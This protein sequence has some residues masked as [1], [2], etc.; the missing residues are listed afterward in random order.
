MSKK[1]HG[2]TT[3][4]IKKEVNEHIRSFCRKYNVNASAIT[5]LMWV[6]YISSSTYIKQ[7]MTMDDT[8][9]RYLIEASQITPNNLD[10]LTQQLWSS[11]ISASVS[12]SI[13]LP[14]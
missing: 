12:G 14:R 9:K 5:E 2:Y 13:S 10:Y 6:N 11:Y 8:A 3:V 1:N 4:Q 7:V